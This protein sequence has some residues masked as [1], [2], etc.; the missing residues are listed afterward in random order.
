LPP[1]LVAH[2]LLGAD[3]DRRA[4]FDIALLRVLPAEKK[5]EEKK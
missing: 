1:L 5:G 2:H 3:M 4:R